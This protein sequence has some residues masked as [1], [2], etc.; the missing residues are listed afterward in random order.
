[1]KIGVPVT[2]SKLIRAIPSSNPENA[3]IDLALIARR[4]VV[5]RAV[6]FPGEGGTAY[7]SHDEGDRRPRNELPHVWSPSVARPV[8]YVRMAHSIRVGTA[9]WSV[10]SLTCRLPDL[11]ARRVRQCAP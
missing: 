1:M 10:S 9:S 2:G 4:R 7:T 5:A 6:D 11:G 3:E 8:R